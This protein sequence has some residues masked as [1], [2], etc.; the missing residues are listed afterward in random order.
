MKHILITGAG[1]AASTN[2]VRSLRLAPEKF[3]LVGTD[4]NPFYLM[5]AET[6]TRYLVPQVKEKTF[7]PILKKIIKKE[8]IDFIHIQN[9]YEVGWFSAHRQQVPAALFLPD[10]KT[11]T[12]CQDK[13]VSYVAWERAGL[14]VPQTIPI[15]NP[16]DLKIAFRS[17][18][19]S[20]WLRATTGAAGRGSIA[21]DDYISAKAWIDFHKGWGTFTAA[22]RLTEH[23]VTWMSLW[24]RGKL[25]VAQGRKR[26]YWEMAKV[27]ASG[28]TGVTGAG[29]TVDDALVDKTAIRAIQAIDSTPHGLFGVDLTYDHNG[30]PNPTEINIGRFFTTHLFFTQAGINMPYIYVLLAFG[31]KPDIP[32]KNINPIAPGK[33]WIRGVDFLPV[34][35]HTNQIDKYKKILNA[36]LRTIS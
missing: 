30:V 26:H 25:I 34:L 21:T 9:D 19:N 18:G 1:G 23:S 5:R 13:Y 10:K 20:L 33:V 29:E 4:A 17:L 27:S 12:T 3:Y 16:R 2:F 35:T 8:K 22:R 31:K 24:H 7:L 14:T 6:N 11:V 32:H 28:I 36:Q 15:R